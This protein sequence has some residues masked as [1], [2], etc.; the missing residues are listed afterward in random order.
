MGGALAPLTACQ[1]TGIPDGR[2]HHTVEAR[3]FLWCG[4]GQVVH[5]E[6]YVYNPVH[7]AEYKGHSGL[8]VFLRQRNW[9]I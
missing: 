8:W 5:G 9:R 6:C 1:M 2:N 3:Y 7:T 4:G